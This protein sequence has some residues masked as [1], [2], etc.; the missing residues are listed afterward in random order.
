MCKTAFESLYSVSHRTLHL[1]RTRVREG[2]IAVKTHGGVDNTNAK[3]IDEEIMVQWFVGV[4]DEIGDVVPVRV[5]VKEVKPGISRRYYS[6]EDHTLLPSYLTWNFLAEQYNMFLDD[7]YIDTP[8]PSASSLFR[9]LT[10]QCPQI[11]IRAPRSQ[12]CDLCA[13]Y[14]NS[15]DANPDGKE[16]EVLGEHI[17]EAK[18]MRS[19]CDTFDYSGTFL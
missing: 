7:N 2:D 4:S 1:Y 6:H 12:V 5:R 17:L 3:E 11:R 14:R 13:I 9:I 10:K 18:A 8:R 16:V 19:V 15:M